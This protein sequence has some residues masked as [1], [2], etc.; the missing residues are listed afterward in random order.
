MCE[1]VR[2]L[3]TGAV[4]FAPGLGHRYLAVYD[5]LGL[6]DVLVVAIGRGL[7]IALRAVML[8]PAAAGPAH[9]GEDGGLVE[10][11]QVPLE[12]E[13]RPHVLV[14]PGTEALVVPCPRRTAGSPVPRAALLLRGLRRPSA[15]RSGGGWRR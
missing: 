1:R 7:L 6:Q 15:V 12:V 4:L 9:L 10:Q 14:G 3:L 2:F 13:V 11:S 5:G 8:R